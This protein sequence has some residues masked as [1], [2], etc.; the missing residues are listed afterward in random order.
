[1]HPTA[2]ALPPSFCRRWDARSQISSSPGFG[3]L[4]RLLRSL[5]TPLLSGFLLRQALVVLCGSYTLFSDHFFLDL[6]ATNNR[7]LAHWLS[8]VSLAAINPGITPRLSTKP[9]CA[10]HDPCFYCMSD[11]INIGFSCNFECSAAIRMWLV[12]KLSEVNQ[13]NRSIGGALIS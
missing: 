2:E 4:V 12:V 10:K 6:N 3:G 7:E 9:I 8:S 11:L 5:L 13:T 1:M